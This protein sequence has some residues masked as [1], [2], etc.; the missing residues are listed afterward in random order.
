ML[1]AINN[2]NMENRLPEVETSGTETLRFVKIILDLMPFPVFI[3]DE[4]RNYYLVNNL[5]AGLFGISEEEIIGKSDHQFIH[6]L[7][8]LAVIV[9]SDNEVLLHRKTVELP[10]QTFTI[11]GKSHVFRTYKL[12]I[13]NPFTGQ[14]NILGYSADVTDEVQ[15]NKLKKVITMCSNPFMS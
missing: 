1:Y 6:D 9:S 14:T 2:T 5:E 4:D 15:L 10:N 3:K 12:P 11:S 8:E 7:Q 13:T